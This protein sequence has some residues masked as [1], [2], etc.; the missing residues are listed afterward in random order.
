MPESDA[1]AQQFLREAEVWYESQRAKNGSMNTNV[2]NVG[3]VVS[4]ML[5]E[6][7][8]WG[9]GTVLLIQHCTETVPLRQSCGVWWAQQD[10]N[11][12]PTDYESAAL[13][14]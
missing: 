9:L 5:A 2:M 12:R 10:L 14:N 3:L 13:T 1:L 6:G 11:L 7:L 4:R 8:P